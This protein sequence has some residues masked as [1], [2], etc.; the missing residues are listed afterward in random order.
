MKSKILL[1]GL[2]A[3]LLLLSACVYEAEDKPEPAEE[4]VVD[5]PKETTTEPVKTVPTKPVPS[6]DPEVQELLN[7]AKDVDNF[8]YLYEAR[9]LNPFGSFEQDVT[10]EA[11]VRG[12][13]A[14]KILSKATKLRN[15]VYYNEIYLNTSKKEERM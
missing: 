10:F 4:P 13:Q 15:E 8:Y 5:E 12:D 9:K 3:S 14:R 7:E 2:I 1:V 11:Y 6:Y